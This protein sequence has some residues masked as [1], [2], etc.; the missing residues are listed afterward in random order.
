M[1]TNNETNAFQKPLPPASTASESSVA[2]FQ[3]PIDPKPGSSSGATSKK[4]KAAV[5]VEHHVPST[6]SAIPEVKNENVSEEQEVER[7]KL[8]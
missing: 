7:R 6:T 8:Q 2:T 1:T 4:Q 5:K 3:K